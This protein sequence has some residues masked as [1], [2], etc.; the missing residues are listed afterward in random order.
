LEAERPG[1]LSYTHDTMLE[2]SV[3]LPDDEL[4]ILIGADSL[5][6]L[7]TWRNAEKLVENWSIL[8]FPR[9][10]VA[11]GRESVLERLRSRWPEEVAVRLFDTILDFVPIEISSTVI[12]EFFAE[13]DQDRAKRFLPPEVFEYINTKGVYGKG[14]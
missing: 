4:I 5:M 2:L 8:T 6:N 9:G 13:N 11:R 14:K 3:R 10:R 12:R 1:I 7:H